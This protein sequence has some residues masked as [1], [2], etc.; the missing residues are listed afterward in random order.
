MEVNNL[1]VVVV[2]PK[3]PNM[4]RMTVHLSDKRKSLSNYTVTK[5]TYW[6]GLETNNGQITTAKEIL[7]ALI[8]NQSKQYRNEGL[9]V[10]DAIGGAVE[11][12]SFQRWVELANEWDRRYQAH[13]RV[14]PDGM[15]SFSSLGQWSVL[16][17]DRPDDEEG[18]LLLMGALLTVET[19]RA[20]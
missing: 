2:D 14:V 11:S 4:K 19:Q 20:S 13:G 1:A 10:L 18:M 16:E 6:V 17:E 15:L 3:H 9:R 7:R 12:R 5:V 8:D